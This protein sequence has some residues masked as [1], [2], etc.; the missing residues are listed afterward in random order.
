VD[1][2]QLTTFQAVIGAG[3]SGTAKAAEAK[4]EG[5]QVTLLD[6]TQGTEVVAVYAGPTLIVRTPDGMLHM[7]AKEI[8]VATGAAEIQPVC[9]GSDLAGIVSIGDV[10]KHRVHEL[11]G[12]NTALVEYI[13]S[14]R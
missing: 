6:A 8:V 2:V 1:Q 7:R 9:P 3:R 11:E 14:G 4:R 5:R 10:V 13:Q 12:E